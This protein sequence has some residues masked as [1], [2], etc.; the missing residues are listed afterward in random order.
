MALPAAIVATMMVVR[1]ML[2]RM[3]LKILSL[4]KSSLITNQK[5]RTIVDQDIGNA[6]IAIIHTKVAQLE[7]GSIFLVLKMAQSR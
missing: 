3:V 4:R 1:K 6:T 7:S 2:P 5:E